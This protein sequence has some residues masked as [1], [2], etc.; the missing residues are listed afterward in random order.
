MKASCCLPEEMPSQYANT[1]R[2]YKFSREKYM[3]FYVKFG[4][5]CH[6]LTFVC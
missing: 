5:V 3:A 2:S 6:P 4:F 1:E